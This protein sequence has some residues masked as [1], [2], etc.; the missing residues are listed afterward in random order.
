VLDH[1]TK[2]NDRLILSFFFDFSDTTRQTLDGMLRSLA[3]QF[4]QGAA[5]F[6]D[7]LDAT[8]EAHQDGCDQPATRTLEDV[9]CKMLAVQKKG[10][11]VLDAL[12]ESTTRDELL[13][14]MKD[15]VSRPELGDVQLICT[16]RPEPEFMRNIPSLIGEENCLAL[17]KKSVN[18]DIRSYIAAQLSQ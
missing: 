9:V 6:A 18:A 1:L 2:G 15:V 8:F 16:G 10:S 14:W 3:F 5:G 13:L 4:Y 17:D 12:D 7:L 11:I